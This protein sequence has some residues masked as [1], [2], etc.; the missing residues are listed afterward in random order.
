MRRSAFGA[1][2]ELFDISC[3]PLTAQASFTTFVHDLWLAAPPEMTAFDLI[4]MFNMFDPPYALGQHYFVSN[5]NNASDPT[6]YA[7]WDFTSTGFK[8]DPN[9]AN[10]YVVAYRTGD[11]P[12]PDDPTHDADWLS[13]SPILIDGKPDGQ[14]ADQVFRLHSNGGNPP[15]SVR[16]YKA[17]RHY[18]H[19]HR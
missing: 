2:T 10:A 9:G 7:K 12:S 16:F 14:L 11:V 3:I 1:V 17:K 5:P 19:E 6:I 13:L 8:N 18:K 15:T 4:S